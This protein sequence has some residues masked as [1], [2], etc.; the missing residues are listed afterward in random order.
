M[1]VCAM[2]ALLLCGAGLFALF[3]CFE[4]DL[5]KALDAA[6]KGDSDDNLA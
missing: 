1:S 3:R 5:N 4:R 6:F 2:I